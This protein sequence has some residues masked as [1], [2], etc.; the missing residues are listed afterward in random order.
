MKNIA[1]SPLCPLLGACWRQWYWML[2]TTE[3]TSDSSGCAAKVFGFLYLGFRS[4]SCYSCLSVQSA[5][6]QVSYALIM[7]QG[8]H[9]A[10]ASASVPLHY[11]MPSSTAKPH[12]GW[13]SPCSFQ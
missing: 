10:N 3:C 7:Q 4:G 11:R 2:E 8:N 6:V 5:S 9:K 12:G 1:H 13:Q